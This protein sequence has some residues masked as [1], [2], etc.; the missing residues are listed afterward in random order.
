MDAVVIRFLCLPTSTAVA[1]QSER[2]ERLC[3][4]S[5]LSSFLLFNPLC[6]LP[7]SLLFSRIFAMSN[8]DSAAANNETTPPPMVGDAFHQSLGL[9]SGFPNAAMVTGSPEWRQKNAAAAANARHDKPGGS[10]EK[11]QQIQEIWASGKYASRDR[12]A[13]EECAALGMALSTARR[14]L[15]GTPNPKDE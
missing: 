5:P 11:K 15:I 6:F 10:R 14:A 3:K 9:P 12:C 2:I 7:L 1:N 4:V 8:E 13:E